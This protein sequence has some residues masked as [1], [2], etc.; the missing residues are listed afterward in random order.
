[1]LSEVLARPTEHR[2]SISIGKNLFVSVRN[3][4]KRRSINKVEAVA[5]NLRAATARF[6]TAT[7]LL[8]RPTSTLETPITPSER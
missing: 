2:S 5:E 7:R 3:A 4:G 8:K 1:M 6:P